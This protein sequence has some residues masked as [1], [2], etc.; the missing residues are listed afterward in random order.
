MRTHGDT[1]HTEYVNCREIDAAITLTLY[2]F[3]NCRSSPL[4]LRR[5]TCSAS[6]GQE[7][8]EETE[9]KNVRKCH[10]RF[11]KYRETCKCR[12][13]HFT[14]SIVSN[15]LFFCWVCSSSQMINLL[16]RKRA[17]FGR[18]YLSIFHIVQL[19]S[20][21]CKFFLFLFLFSFCL[22]FQWKKKVKCLDSMS[23]DYFCI[24]QSQSEQ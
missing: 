10:W 11:V 23:A 13:L 22:V 9:K 15:I 6:Y 4:S 21:S 20:F 24:Y 14:Y 2:I 5:S 7:E 19:I 3:S 8:A 1:P 16:C 18:D 12:T 17:P